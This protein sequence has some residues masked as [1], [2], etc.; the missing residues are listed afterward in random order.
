MQRLGWQRGRV[1]LALGACGILFAK[2]PHA[3]TKLLQTKGALPPAAQAV[4]SESAVAASD[5]LQ[6]YAR[7]GTAADAA[8]VAALVAGVAAPSSSGLGGGGFALGWDAQTGQPY[9]I[10]F[11]E[12]APRAVPRAPFEARP[13]GPDAIGHLVGV[14]GEARGLFALHQRAGK[15]PWAELVRIAQRRAETGFAVSPFLAG[16]LVYSQ[17][18]IQGRAALGFLFPGGKPALAGTRVTNPKL[19]RTLALLATRG[20]DVINQGEIANE[21]V[22]TVR[23]HGGTMTLQ[24]LAD[25]RPT[26]REPI[27]VRYAKS[28]VFTMPPPSAGGILLAQV[29]SLLSPDDLLRFGQDS[30]AY[31]HVLAEAMRGAFADRFRYLADPDHTAVPRQ[32]LLDADRLERRRQAIAV[33]RTHRMPLF[34]GEEHGT[35]ALVTSDRARNVVSLTTTVNNSFGSGLTLEEAGIVLNDELNDFA[36]MASA[37]PFG[38]ED[39]PNF[40]RGGARPVSSM[41]PT[42]VVTD[43]VPRLAL[44]GSGGMRIASNVTQ[45]LLDVLVFGTAPAE[46]VARPRLSIPLDGGTLRLEGDVPASMLSDLAWRGELVS[47]EPR[48]STA[49]QVLEFDGTRVRG[50]ADDRKSGAALVR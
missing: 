22:A 17:A 49:V 11:R 35:H 16:S 9:C 50:A 23:A 6:V 38:L 13:L 44:G 29:L 36:T 3:E 32:F 47:Q 40:A 19:A 18:K 41:T 48:N 39:T 28:D 31:R 14:P 2:L 45:V 21:I 46:A 1:L 25:Y 43:G 4:A 34:V 33:D 12:V 42:I 7:G 30:A 37:R 26:E 5:A 8:I 24:D 27:R 10:D 15:L 20:P